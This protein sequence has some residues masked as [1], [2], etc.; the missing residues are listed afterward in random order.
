MTEQ[1]PGAQPDAELARSLDR[2][3]GPRRLAA[4]GPVNLERRQQGDR[5]R[6]KPGLA[7]LFG[8]IFVGLD[9]PRRKHASKAK[10]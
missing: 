3:A 2:R 6:K 10:R 1:Q 4:G 5:R 9:R 7:A 8:A